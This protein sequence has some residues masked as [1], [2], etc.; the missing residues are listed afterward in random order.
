M[1]TASALQSPWYVVCGNH[2]HYGNCS[3]EIAYSK[4]SNRWNFP[5]YYYTKVSPPPPSPS[6]S[7]THAL[8]HA[9]SIIQDF[10]IPD[11]N[12]TLG[13]LLID[14]VLLAGLTHPTFGYLPPP[15]PD[16]VQAAEDQWQFIQD[17]LDKWSQQSQKYK[18][19]IVAGHYPGSMRPRRK[20]L[21]LYIVLVLLHIASMHFEPPPSLSLQFGLWLSMVPPRCWWGG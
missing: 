19:T 4:V 7:P 17:T 11:S 3:A 16:S 6:L 10:D 18:W 14:T 13:I 5:D 2:D 12:S 15:G 21:L 8:S 9:H 20:H 1:F